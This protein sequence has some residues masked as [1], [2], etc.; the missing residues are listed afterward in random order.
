MVFNLPRSVILNV[1]LLD[2]LH[3]VIRLGPPKPLAELPREIPRQ[4][5]NRQR[6]HLDPKDGAGKEPRYDAVVLGREAKLGRHRTVNGH[7][8]SPDSHRARNRDNVILR[9]VVGHQRR[10]A[11][12]RQ[13]HGSIHGRA[14]SPLA[15]RLSIRLNAVVNPK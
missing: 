10:L 4:A 1:I 8:H 6:R 3:V 7:K 13:Q 14:P 15:G 5:E 11:Q 12:H 9:P 2:L